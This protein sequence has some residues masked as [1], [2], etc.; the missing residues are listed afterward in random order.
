MFNKD[1]KQVSCVNVP[2]LMSLCSKNLTLE[3]FQLCVLVV[4]LIELTF[5]SQISTISKNWNHH[6]NNTE[7]KENFQIILIIV[8]WNFTVFQ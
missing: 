5:L 1:I 6:W 2:N 7:Q 8:F 4:Y 3:S